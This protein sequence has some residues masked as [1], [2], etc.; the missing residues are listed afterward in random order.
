M[1]FKVSNMVC[2]SVQ[3]T[4]KGFFFSN[5]IEWRKIINLFGDK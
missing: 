3:N 1:I 5:D 2:V 4:M